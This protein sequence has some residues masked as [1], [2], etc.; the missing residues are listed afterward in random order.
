[1]PYDSAGPPPSKEMAE[2]F[3]Y[4]RE[5]WLTGSSS[6]LWRHSHHV[7]WGSSVII[8]TGRALLST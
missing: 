2:V 7:A 8:P 4:C 3:N 1:L 6:G 5:R